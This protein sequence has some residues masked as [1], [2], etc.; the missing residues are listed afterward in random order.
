[1]CRTTLALASAL[2]A[3]CLPA[4]AVTDRPSETTAAAPA[5]GPARATRGQPAAPADHPDGGRLDANGLHAAF[6]ANA[7]DADARFKGK[8]LTVRGT[9]MA[10]KA[11]RGRYGVVFV[12]ADLPTRGKLLPGVVAWVADDARAEFRDVN[13]TAFPKQVI[14]VRG[15]CAGARSDFF[16]YKDTAVA[17]ENC[18]RAPD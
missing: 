12:V 4:A 8:V 9:V 6:V 11:E 3:G 2:L 17:L 16:M 13:A 18:R 1:V 15:V 7:L 10:M 5:A 14:T